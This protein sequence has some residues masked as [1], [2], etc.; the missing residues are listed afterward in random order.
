M[1]Q[2]PVWASEKEQLPCPGPGIR[3]SP[4]K[5]SFGSCNAYCAAQGQ[6]MDVD[7]YKLVLLVGGE[8]HESSEHCDVCSMWM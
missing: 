7:V 6:S 3:E 2:L 8:I 4:A 5:A 1:P